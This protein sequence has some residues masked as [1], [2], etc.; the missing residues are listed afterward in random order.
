MTWI[1]IVWTAAWWLA[2][3][4]FVVSAAVFACVLVAALVDAVRRHR[5]TRHAQARGDV[6]DLA[7]HRAAQRA[8]AGFSVAERAEHVRRAERSVVRERSAR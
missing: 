2:I 7:V 5:A 8:A 1:S 3:A 6:V 4:S